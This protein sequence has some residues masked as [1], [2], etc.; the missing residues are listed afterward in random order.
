MKLIAFS[1]QPDWAQTP[2]HWLERYRAAL[3]VAE[4]DRES[5]VVFPEYA[6]LEA[7]LYGDV[8]LDARG[9]MTRGADHF[10][11]Y[12]DGIRALVAETGATI[13]GGSGFARVGDSIINRAL[14]C[15]PEGEGY[16]NKRT[17]TLYERNI[18]L[19]AGEAS[20]LFETRF[21]KVAGLICYDSE[22]PRLS[23][24]YV[25]AGA[26][27]LLVPSCTDTEH[28]AMRVEIACRAR[29]LEGQMIVAMAPLVGEVPDCEVIDVNFGQ[30]AIFGPPDG[31][32]P[33][34]GILAT[35][36]KHFQSTATLETLGESVAEARKGGAVS[37]KTHWPESETPQKAVKTLNLR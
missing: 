14:F 27:I 22:F 12:C 6:A 5:L 24:H 23:R 10:E 32:F 34:T 20:P 4:A 28:G 11:S 18:D 2:D 13:L 31:A 29:A 35:G 7:A 19:S 17:P 26:D 21:G 33:A 30:A 1:W 9:W 25:E 37:V 3:S 36:T 8:N 16:I 15:A